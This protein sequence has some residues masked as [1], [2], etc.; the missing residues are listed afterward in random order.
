MNE[1]EELYKYDNENEI[2][3]REVMSMLFGAFFQSENGDWLISPESIACIFL[4]EKSKKHIIS[5]I[6]EDSIKNNE[7]LGENHHGNIDI[8][9][10][11]SIITDITND[12]EDIK[13]FNEYEKLHHYDS[14]KSIHKK[15][16]KIHKE[17]I[18][19]ESRTY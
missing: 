6:I 1:K 4:G 16:D 13:I 2:R 18:P 12:K 11:K 10:L 7:S 15:E 17:N 3:W 19:T 14:K 9:F 5:S 8:H